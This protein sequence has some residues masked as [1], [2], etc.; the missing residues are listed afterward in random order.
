V[1]SSLAALLADV[2]AGRPPAPDGRVTV[3]PPPSPRD[4]GVLAF[5]AHHVVFAD[6]TAGWVEASLPGGD[7]LAAPLSA[8]F[9][10]ALENQLHRRSGVIDLLTVAPAQSGPPPLDLGRAI[11]RDHPR[12]RRAHDYRDDVTVWEGAGATVAIGRGV[13]G[14]YE[15]SVEVDPVA[16]NRG[17]GRRA[18]LSARHL[19]PAG[20]P[21]W[22][23][24]A[25]GNVASVRAFLAAGF[26]PVGAE[27]LLTRD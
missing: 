4:S 6:V 11:S 10:T 25:P 18:L 8:R 21:L 23:Q 15:V 27:V 22:A 7:H 16:R 12:V 19:V 13:A 2:A 9:L 1:I 26:T 14:R 24:I 20:Q 17:I 3:L 5:T